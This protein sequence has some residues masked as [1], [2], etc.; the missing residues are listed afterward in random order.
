MGTIEK[1][2]KKL[3]FCIA[4]NKIIKPVNPVSIKAYAVIIPYSFLVI[5]EIINI[6][7]PVINNGEQI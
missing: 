6:K 2:L 7:N 4:K 1:I 3:L 5:F